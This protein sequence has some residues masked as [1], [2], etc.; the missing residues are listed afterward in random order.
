MTEALKHEDTAAE[1]LMGEIVDEFLQRVDRGERPEADEYV[2]RYPQPAT[3]RR[4]MCPA[5]RVEWR[6]G[7]KGRSP[8]QPGPT[9]R[10]GLGRRR[11]APT[12][13][14]RPRRPF[15]PNTR[16]GTRPSSARRPTW[17]PGRP[18]HSNMRMGKAW[19]TGTSS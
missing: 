6:G 11:R 5:W 9:R 13:R 16:R 12:R 17:A 7:G 4:K 2:R 10:Q 15:R 19:Y 3:V 18:R 14:P 8:P 1:A